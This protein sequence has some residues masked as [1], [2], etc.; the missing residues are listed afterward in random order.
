MKK[1]LQTNSRKQ[2]CWTPY[3]RQSDAVF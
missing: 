2:I 3:W 1:M